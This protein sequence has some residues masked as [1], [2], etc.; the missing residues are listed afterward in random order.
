MLKYSIGYIY[1]YLIS[2]RV[3]P[4]RLGVKGTH[5]VQVY[6]KYWVYPKY[7]VI[8]NTL[9]YPMPDYFQKYIGYQKMS[10][11]RRVLGTRWP[12]SPAQEEKS[13]VAARRIRPGIVFA[14]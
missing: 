8:P 2:T 7:R 4:G 11:S 9:G 1:G 12:L 6:L 10:G 3:F 13:C 14:D 5:D